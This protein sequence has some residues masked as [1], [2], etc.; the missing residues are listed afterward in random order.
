MGNKMAELPGQ[1]QEST[2]ELSA[3]AYERSA[4]EATDPGVGDPPPTTSFEVV[5]ASGLL[6]LRHYR[7]D[8]GSAPLGP[9]LL[10]YSLLRRPY[11]LDLLP[12]RSVVRSFLHQGF[13]VYLAEWL[14]PQGADSWRGFEAYVEHDL[15]R[16]VDCVRRRERIDGVSLIGPCFGGSLAVIYAALHPDNVQQLVTCALP[17]ET[18]PPVAPAVVEYLTHVYGNLPAWFIHAWL[19]ARTQSLLHLGLY[20]AEDFDE[21]ELAESGWGAA[22]PVVSALHRW[23]NSDVPMAGRLACEMMRDAYGDAQLAESRLRV[24]G[25]RVALRDIR[26]PVLNITGK[27]DRLVPPA[28]SAALIERVGS[29]ETRNLVFPAGHL[30]LLASLAAQ[31]ELWPRVGEWLVQHGASRDSRAISEQPPAAL[32]PSGGTA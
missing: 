29:R 7:Y 30:G 11:I 18:D 21:P 1:V 16:A 28:S 22:H 23:T 26:C 20:A 17:F 13:S 32:H 8:G 15:G 31:R 19:S 5:D 27:R 12:D 24:G 10:V 25:R 6:R 4:S 9:V 2:N 3:G 14:P